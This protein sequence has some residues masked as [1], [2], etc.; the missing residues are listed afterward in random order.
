MLETIAIILAVLVAA[1]VLVIA[2]AAATRPDTFTCARSTRI[3]APPEKITPLISD[4][5]KWVT[6]S[7]YEKRVFLDMDKMVGNDFAVGLAAMK[8]AVE[9][10]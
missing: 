2:Y 1:V 4:F 3:I 5:K 9:S 6:W 7:P 10:K 8:T